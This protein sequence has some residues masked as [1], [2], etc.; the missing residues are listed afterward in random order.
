[1]S[2]NNI[3][4]R[5]FVELMG[6]GAIFAGLGLAGCGSQVGDSAASTEGAADK[7]TN[8]VKDMT[9]EEEQAAWEKEPFYG[10]TIQVGYNGGACLGAFGIAKSNGFYEEEG[11]ECEIVSMDSASDG[12]GT[13]KVQVAGDHIAT[14][15]VPAVNGVKMTF[16][17]GCQ[18][19]CKGL[20]VLAS[21]DNKSTSD[22]AGKAIATPDGIGESD[23]NIAIRFLDHDGVDINTIEWKV[24]S[25]DAVVQALQ[26][27]EVDGALLSD[28]F[29]KTFVDDGTLRVIRSL[30]FDEDYQKEPCC[31]VAFNSDFI[32][33]NPVT[34]KKFTRA[35]R[36]ASLWINEN[37]AEALDVMFENNWASGDKDVAYEIVKNFNYDMSEKTTRT[38]LTS[39]IEDYKKY[40]LID[41]TDDA[42]TILGKVWAPVLGDE[43]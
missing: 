26:N 19:G 14:L 2:Q 12:V 23:Q 30:T 31:I 38:A 25:T 22:L 16:T 13:G 5:N 39:I 24:V 43:A 4:R 10:K 29:A 21:S 7:I 35:F 17:V 32:S 6:A 36:N 41:S 11:L 27:G 28:Q 18:S 42:E 9:A 1:M 8:E 3:S 34:A 33:E 15:L 20:Y 37:K 40:G